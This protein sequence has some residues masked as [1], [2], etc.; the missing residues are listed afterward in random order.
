M[1][2]CL[3]P[4]QSASDMQEFGI[5]AG[6]YSNFPANKDYLNKSMTVF[7]VAPYVR[8]GK[9]EFSLG[10]Q[11][12][13]QTDALFYSSEHITPQPGFLAGYRFYIFN[14]FGRENLFVHYAFQYLRFRGE[15]DN[16]NMGINEPA[17]WTEKDMYI[18]NVIGLGYNVFFDMNGRFGFFYTLDY[19]ISQRGYNITAPGYEDDS[20]TTRYIWN[21]LSTNLGFSFKICSLKKKGKQ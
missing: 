5:M 2:P 4:A 8:V 19:V 10:M 18:N 17:N 7:Y 20:W 11:Y 13:L 12:P 14:V 21:N 3:L 9:H 6:S 1:L 15:Y 16:L